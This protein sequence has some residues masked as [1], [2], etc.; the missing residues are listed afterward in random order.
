MS[1]KKRKGDHEHNADARAAR[2]VEFDNKVKA[3]ALDGKKSRQNILADLYA[4]K[5]QEELIALPSKMT[6]AKRIDR[7]RATEKRKF[8]PSEPKDKDK[9][10]QLFCFKKL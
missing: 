1:F 5:T 7:L 8:F 6:S 4:G 2:L 10:R 9:S 3:D